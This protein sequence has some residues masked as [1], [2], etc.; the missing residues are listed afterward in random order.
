MI[1]SSDI[2]QYIIIII[3]TMMKKERWRMIGVY[4]RSWMSVSDSDWL[5]LT[6]SSLFKNATLFSMVNMPLTS[7]Y[8]HSVITRDCCT[9]KH[10][11]THTT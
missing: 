7:R 5:L 3:T 1:F 6:V 2:N 4:P 9:R 8:A 11:H 10:T